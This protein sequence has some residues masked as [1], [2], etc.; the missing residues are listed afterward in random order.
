M[1]E[2][3]DT[4]DADED[5]GGVAAKEA[6]D[7]LGATAEMGPDTQA[8]CIFGATRRR[9]RPRK[10]VF[11]R[12]QQANHCRWHVGDRV[13]VRDRDDSEIG[14]SKLGEAD[15]K[16]GTVTSLNP[17]KVC[18]NGG[19]QSFT[20]REI[21]ELSGS[22]SPSPTSVRSNRRGV[23]P[24][25]VEAVKRA[26]KLSRRRRQR[27]KEAEQK[28]QEL[29]ERALMVTKARST[30]SLPKAAEQKRQEE[31]R[32]L[33]TVLEELRTQLVDVKAKKAPSR[34][35]RS[36]P[37]SKGEARPEPKP[38]ALKVLKL[39]RGLRGRGFQ[40]SDVF[41][42]PVKERKELLQLLL[43]PYPDGAVQEA[44]FTEWIAKELQGLRIHFSNA[45]KQHAAEKGPALE[46]LARLRSCIERAQMAGSDPRNL[47][48]LLRSLRADQIGLDSLDLLPRVEFQTL[49]EKMDVKMSGLT[50][51]EV[52]E[53]WKTQ[54]WSRRAKSSAVT[55]PELCSYPPA[56]VIATV[57]QLLKKAEEE[58]AS[59]PMTAWQLHQWLARYD[60]GVRDLGC[61]CIGELRRLSDWV[62]MP[63]LR[64][65][66]DI[67]EWFSK[68]VRREH[69]LRSKAP[70]QRL[71][72]AAQ[73]KAI[74]LLE[75]GEES[76][77]S[78]LFDLEPEF[79]MEYDMYVPP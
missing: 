71:G 14:R 68:E 61:L 19:S 15:W 40:L 27:E 59:K 66:D 3:A 79:T 47:F 20:W 30:S 53:S 34:S 12:L 16:P 26:R 60:A 64:S 41:M 35:S 52:I 58:R 1:A 45:Q 9:I 8:L 62:T 75:D 17:V 51:E 4:T 39:V 13:L 63:P 48:R 36:L 72:Q 78:V 55:E 33:R 18:L 46:A 73:K 7:E 10:T 22:R 23:K 50:K 76:E 25:T 56:Q 65:K 54:L 57:R 24:A 67:L 2:P 11:E 69:T 77:D 28:E 43:H 49:A 70:R 42:L 38:S 5:G 37:V 6:G 74:L 29:E 44:E 21:K 31:V 32:R